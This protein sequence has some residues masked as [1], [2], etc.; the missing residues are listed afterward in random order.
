MTRDFLIDVLDNC[1]GIE[2]NDS[3]Y[4]T[5]EEF[6]L[7]ILLASGPAGVAPINRVTALTLRENY[8]VMVA[9][10]S[11]YYFPYDMIC[12]VKTA[13]RGKSSARTGFRA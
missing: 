8:L 10:E 11:T 13:G 12:G 6:T 2:G 4:T 9:E 5:S 7:A 1:E 3:V